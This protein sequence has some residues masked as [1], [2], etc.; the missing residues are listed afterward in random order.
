LY[1][2][3]GLGSPSILNQAA[4]VGG[5]TVVA[6]PGFIGNGMIAN[7]GCGACDVPLFGK[8]TWFDHRFGAL[9]YGAPG[10]AN[11]GLLGGMFGGLLGFGGVRS[12][13]GLGYNN[14][15]YGGL[16]CNTCGLNTLSAVIPNSCGAQ[17]AMPVCGQRRAN[18]AVDLRLFGFGLGFGTVSP[19]FDSR[20]AGWSH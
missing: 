6:A 18:A 10:Y 2:Y 17:I 7:T 9:G 4:V 19:R 15:A 11:R 12:G 5:S 13:Y 3:G 1:G 20:P 16:G 8:R 14:V